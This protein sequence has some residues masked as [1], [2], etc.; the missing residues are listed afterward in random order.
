MPSKV[1]I[2]QKPQ[3]Y[4]ERTFT[5]SDS[6]QCISCGKCWPWITFDLELVRHTSNVCT[7]C[8]GAEIEAMRWREI[9][10][11][12]QK[13]LIKA[14]QKLAKIRGEPISNA[15][16]EPPSRPL[17]TPQQLQDPPGPPAQL[18]GNSFRL[19]P[20]QVRQKFL[21]EEQLSG[22]R[23]NLALLRMR[24]YA[25]VGVTM[26]GSPDYTIEGL[27][28]RV[29]PQ[30][31]E[32]EQEEGYV[33]GYLRGGS[34]TLDA[35]NDR[36]VRGMRHQMINESGSYTVDQNQRYNHEESQIPLIQQQE[37]RYQAQQPYAWRAQP[38]PQPTHRLNVPSPTE[39][40]VQH[41]NVPGP[42]RFPVHHQHPQQQKS[43]L[44]P[45][46]QHQPRSHMQ[47]TSSH[48][49]CVLEGS[50]NASMIH[51]QPTTQQHNLPPQPQTIPHSSHDHRINSKRPASTL[52]VQGQTT[53]RSDEQDDEDDWTTFSFGSRPSKRSKVNDVAQTIALP[54]EQ[55]VVA[56]LTVTPRSSLSSQKI[57]KRQE[58][59]GEE[60][61]DELEDDDEDVYAPKADGVVDVKEEREGAGS[62]DEV[63]DMLI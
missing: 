39:S 26:R 24:L 32:K 29:Q 5:S 8:A 21:S 1:V 36:Q 62:E 53:N 57:D 15:Q 2:Q 51:S 54:K 50:T 37:N 10:L 22:I 25:D 12:M 61:I 4:K 44:A 63:G 47:A 49:P 11:Q 59:D 52:E 40:Q 35:L 19:T 55:K 56:Q 42:T 58:E 41:V 7:R 46:S 33:G 34:R 30:E 6:K 13:D 23:A 45:V 43:H 9:G 38:Q 14:R 60:E 31:K 48:Y 27:E 3:K 17:P 18:R 16:F 28:W 20:G